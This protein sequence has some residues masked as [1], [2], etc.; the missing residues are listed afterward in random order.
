M[1]EDKSI[2]DIVALLD[3][4]VEKGEGRM[5]LKVSDDLPDGTVTTGKSFGRC[6]MTA[7]GRTS[8]DL[9]EALAREDRIKQ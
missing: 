6:D 5:K 7:S 1:K 4:F 9:E 3:G 8:C 2:E